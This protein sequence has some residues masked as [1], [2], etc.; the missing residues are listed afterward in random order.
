MIKFIYAVSY[1]Q[2][3]WRSY[4]IHICM[5]IIFHGIIYAFIGG[6]VVSYCY[7]VSCYRAL[8]VQPIPSGGCMLIYIYE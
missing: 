7:Y 6:W 5:S 2:G 8:H 3:T 4:Y 1:S